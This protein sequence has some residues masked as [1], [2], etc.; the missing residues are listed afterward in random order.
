[1][2]I[3]Q[4]QIQRW[5]EMTDGEFTRA[6]SHLSDA[7]FDRASKARAEAALL[8]AIEHGIMRAVR[9]EQGEIQYASALIH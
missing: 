2:K 3:S 6:T 9:I 1:M 7:D 5:L 8:E 4:R